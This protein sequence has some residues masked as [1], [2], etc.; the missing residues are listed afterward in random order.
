MKSRINTIWI[1][2]TCGLAV[3]VFVLAAALYHSRQVTLTLR[4]QL[5]EA[6]N[7]M[8]SEEVVQGQQEIA[9][10]GSAQTVRVMNG[11]LQQQDENGQ[12]V[13]VAPVE[14]LQQADPILAGRSK[15]Q[16]LIARNREAVQNGTISAEQI[17]PLLS[18]Q[19]IMAGTALAAA[20]Q[21]QSATEKTAAQAVKPTNNNTTTTTTAPAATPAPAQQPTVNNDNS[22]SDDSSSDSGSSDSGSSDNSSSDNS[23]SD[24]GNSDSG[25]SDSSSSDG[26]SSDSGSSDSSSSDGGSSDSGSSDSGSSDS[27]SGDDSSNSGDGEDVGWTDEVL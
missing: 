22:S 20:S 23:S 4:T 7:S 8:L 3:L 27:G 24:S 6:Q 18:R 2:L 21:V 13:D 25:S 11:V 16:E 26:G 14:E 17:S 9:A 1:V 19:S 15:M 10:A 5:A 12:W